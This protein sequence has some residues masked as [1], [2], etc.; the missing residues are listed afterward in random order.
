MLPLHNYALKKHNSWHLEAKATHA[1]QPSD[2]E[3]LQTIIR[4]HGQFGLWL[5]LGSN[6]LL[7]EVINQPVILTQKF[8]NQMHWINEHTLYLQAGMTCA[9]AAKLC[10][11]KGFKEAVFFAGIPGTI[12][13]ALMMNAGAF[14][15]ETWQ[16]VLY[17]DVIDE[18]GDIHRCEPKDFIIHYRRIDVP[19]PLRFV[20]AAFNFTSDSPETAQTHMKSCVSKRN[21]TQPIGTFNCGS[22][23]KNPYP[24]YAAKLI[25]DCNLKGYEYSHAQVSPKHANFII[26]LGNATYDGILTLIKHIQTN[27]L[28]SFDVH[29]ET[30]VIIVDRD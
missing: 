1:Y 27:V 12:G 15:Y 8:L 10:A 21:A 7:P 26:N 28:K 9:K 25:E 23:F 20:G 17:V 6:V 3:T 16:S 30:E 5:G 18:K 14:G 22:V 13:G 2:I 29:L 4:H 19:F 11:K 24:H